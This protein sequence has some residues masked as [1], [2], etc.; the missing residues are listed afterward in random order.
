MLE[1]YVEALKQSLSLE[2]MIIV[3]VLF[4]IVSFVKIWIYYKQKRFY[5]KEFFSDSIKTQES[6]IKD[7][8]ADFRVSAINTKDFHQYSIAIAFLERVLNKKAY[9]EY[10]N[11]YTEIVYIS[12]YI[13]RLTRKGILSE[14]LAKTMIG[15]YIV[16]SKNCSEEIYVAYYISYKSSKMSII[17]EVLKRK[18]YGQLSYSVTLKEIIKLVKYLQ[19]A[20][21]IYEA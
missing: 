2:V 16:I 5:R 3:Y 11:F 10:K 6:K 9:R 19:F 12:K 1:K 4:L 18:I 17:Y 15:M 8:I 14:E 13:K 21:E 20:R 7:Y